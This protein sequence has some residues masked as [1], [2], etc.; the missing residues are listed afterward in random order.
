MAT[1]KLPEGGARM[2]FTSVIDL[3]ERAYVF[4]AGIVSPKDEFEE[5]ALASLVADGI[6]TKGKAED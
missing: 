2:F 4:S 5:E 6:A 3:R 1:Y